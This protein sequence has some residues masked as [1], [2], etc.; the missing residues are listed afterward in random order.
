[1]SLFGASILAMSALG[2]AAQAHTMPRDAAHSFSVPA[3]RQPARGNLADHVLYAYAKHNI[4][5]TMRIP[6]ATNTLLTKNGSVPAFK[7]PDAPHWSPVEIGGQA[8]NLT[9]HTTNSDL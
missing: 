8:F 5:P 6:A 2:L 7:V 4:T 1:M 9:I 3:F